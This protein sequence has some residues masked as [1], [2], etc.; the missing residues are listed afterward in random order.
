MQLHNI[1]RKKEFKP[2]TLKSTTE[3]PASVDARNL[4]FHL[5]QISQWIGLNISNIRK[6][7]F[8]R[9]RNLSQLRHSIPSDKVQTLIYATVVPPEFL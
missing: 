1:R 4:G 7:R 2:L 8:P 9:I 6:T 5:D 3:I